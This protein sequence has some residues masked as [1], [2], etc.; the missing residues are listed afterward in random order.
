MFTSIVLRRPKK[1]TF[2]KGLLERGKI[3]MSRFSK[4]WVLFQMVVKRCYDDRKSF[5]MQP[6]KMKAVLFVTHFLSQF[7]QFSRK[8]IYT[9]LFFVINLA[10]SSR[11]AL[12]RQ[13]RGFLT[14][15]SYDWLEFLYCS[16]AH[17]SKFSF[18]PM[19]CLKGYVI[20]WTI[21]GHS[22]EPNYIWHTLDL[23][24]KL[25]TCK[26]SLLYKV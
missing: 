7:S 15:F 9:Y 14:I 18:V 24:F 25:D 22:L 6:S 12:A 16:S 20:C 17:F 3:S 26:V 23:Q 8:I 11:S 1:I 4:S 10:I 19:I 2:R 5:D 21:G 13:V